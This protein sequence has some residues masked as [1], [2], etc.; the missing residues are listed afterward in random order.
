MSNVFEVRDGTRRRIRLTRERWRHITV[1]HPFMTNY[2]NNV[3]DTIKSPDKI[4]PREKGDIS[5]YYKHYKHREG[6]LKFLKV[7]V[8]YLNSEGFIITS[9]F[10]KGIN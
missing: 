7:V 10:V 4:V 2:L 5:D 1:K 9:Y 8:K 6:N 3:E